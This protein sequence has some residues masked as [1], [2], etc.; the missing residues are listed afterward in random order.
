MLFLRIFS[1]LLPRSQAWSLASG[2]TLRSFFLGLTGVFEDARTFADEAY[3]DLFPNTTRR[4]RDWEAQ[5]GLVPGSDED[6]RRQALDSAWKAVGGQ[7]PSYL[8][9]VLQAAGFPVFV[10]EWWAPEDGRTVATNL[11]SVNRDDAPVITVAGTSKPDVGSLALR[12]R[13][14]GD[15]EAIVDVIFPGTTHSFTSTVDFHPDY[16]ADVPPFSFNLS[17]LGI[18][19]LTIT[20]P[21][22]LA[23]YLPESDLYRAQA[24]PATIRDPR[25]YTR[26]VRVGTVRCGLPSALCGRSTARCSRFL[27]NDPGYLVNG[28]LTRV[29]PPLIPSDPSKWRHFWYISAETFGDSL[30]LPSSR[31]DEFER[32]VLKL[33]P[34]QT[35]VVVMATWD[36]YIVVDEDGYV[37]IDETT[38]SVVVN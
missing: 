20:V 13:R 18:S 31:R 8:Q 34:S 14:S 33:K 12:V 21:G 22:P 16:Y 7:D 25:D 19:D 27:A 17:F 3:L 26:P 32:L 35:W 5:F 38:G 23:D 36:S 10:H 1:H 4:L 30:A 11:V 2:K 28:N 6:N 15:E 24:I 29:A 9:E 37:V